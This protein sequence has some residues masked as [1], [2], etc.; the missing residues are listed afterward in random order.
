MTIK[1]GMKIDHLFV[2]NLKQPYILQ[3]LTHRGYYVGEIDVLLFD[4]L[5][6]RGEQLLAA[7]RR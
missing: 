2:R 1:P 4:A 7:I 6:G 5:E 3:H